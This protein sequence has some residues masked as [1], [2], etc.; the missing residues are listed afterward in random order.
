MKQ[1]AIHRAAAIGAVMLM[2]VAFGAC[3][4]SSSTPEVIYVTPSPTPTPEVT[5]TPEETPTSEATPTAAPTPTP[6]PTAPPVVTP[7]PGSTCS[8]TAANNAWFVAQAPHFT[9]TLYCAV[10]PSGWSILAD[11]AH[12]YYDNGGKLDT[13]Y[14][15]PGG[16]LLTVKEGAFCTSGAAAC[17][18]YTSDVGPAQF[19]DLTGELYINSGAYVLYVNPG[20]NHAYELDGPAG[21][22]E[23]TFRALA[24]SFIKVPAA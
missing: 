5:A 15:G 3:K 20:T 13:T 6:V 22:S 11:G 24:G 23:A 4:S 18:P 7:P 17:A 12:A 14:K 21:M 19:A 9:W 16:I 10:L 2:A 1:Q 8:R